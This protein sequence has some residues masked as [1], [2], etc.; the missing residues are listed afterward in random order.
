MDFMELYNDCDVVQARMFE[1]LP[2]YYNFTDVEIEQI[3]QVVLATLVL[4]L[5]EPI[6]SRNMYVSK[7]LRKPIRRI[8]EILKKEIYNEEVLETELSDAKLMMFST[9][10]WTVAQMALFLD[11]TNGNFTEI[12]YASQIL[13]ELHSTPD[14][15][16]MDC[17]WIE[18]KL[19][20]KPL[21]FEGYCERD[22]K[23]TFP[24]YFK[25]LISRSFVFTRSHY[26]KECSEQF[27][28]PTQEKL[29][30]QSILNMLLNQL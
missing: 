15:A 10:D 18:T 17:F 19:N 24:E 25:M 6:L 5:E 29:E 30:A 21:L 20:G 1:N 26:S 28:P 13:I 2:L 27:T 4:P 22:N 11:A 9:H 14:C 3:G 7:Q 23:C 8:V 16:D 12:P